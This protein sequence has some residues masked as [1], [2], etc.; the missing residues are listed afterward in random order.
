MQGNLINFFQ[1]RSS[2][3]IPATPQTLGLAA[4]SRRL[5]LFARGIC[6]LGIIHLLV[7]TKYAYIDARERDAACCCLQRA[8]QIFRG[9]VIKQTGH[10][11]F[12]QQCRCRRFRSKVCVPFELLVLKWEIVSRGTPRE[13]WS[14]QMQMFLG[15][16]AA[17]FTFF[18]AL[19][20]IPARQ[21][22]QIQLSGLL[23]C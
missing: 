9:E 10:L 16:A 6:M 21:F 22:P 13:R 14:E 17:A 18:G 5:K 20:V 4:L 2:S 3:S 8:H 19:L 1:D 23:F 12:R 7:D 11:S 15:A